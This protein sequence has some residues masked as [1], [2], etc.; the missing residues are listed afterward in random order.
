MWT[1]PYAPLRQIPTLF[2][3]SA[4]VVNDVA[5]SPSIFLYPD[6]SASFHVTNDP[7][8]LQQ[9]TLFE[10]HDQ[11]YIGNGKGLHIQS[12]SSNT[13]AS[14]IHPHTPFTVQN[15]SLIP[16]KTNNLISVS[17]FCR[18]NNVYFVFSTDKYLAKSQVYNAIFL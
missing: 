12:T 3:P 5:S 14:P 1:R 17:Q 16:S 9:L 8:N 13:F 6:S 10:G 15:L 7:K 4:F 11:I 2:A 18:D